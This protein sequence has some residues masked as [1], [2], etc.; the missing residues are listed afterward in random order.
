V[1]PKVLSTTLSVGAW[2]PCAA[3]SE[4]F[5]SLPHI[6]PTGTSRLHAFVAG[7]SLRY[8]KVPK[9]Q[10]VTGARESFTAMSSCT[11]RT[12][13]GV[14]WVTPMSTQL[15]AAL[16]AGRLATFAFSVGERFR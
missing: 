13:P 16:P 6:K 8:T 14:R 15:P 10:L 2:P 7:A 4:R 5:G 1:N 9:N 11:S 3:A 12:F